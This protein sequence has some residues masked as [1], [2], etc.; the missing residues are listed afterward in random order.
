MRKDNPE[1]QLDKLC[2]IDQL[3]GLTK[4]TTMADQQATAI[5]PISKRLIETRLSLID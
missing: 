5:D 1:T 3:L 4:T 2:I